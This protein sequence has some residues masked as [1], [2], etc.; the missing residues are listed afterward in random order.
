[1]TDETTDRD[2][3]GGPDSEARAS[4][5]AAGRRTSGRPEQGT[6]TSAREGEPGPSGPEGEENGAG[7][8]RRSGW[9]AGRSVWSETLSD[10][11]DVVGEVLESVRG[12]SAPGGRFPRY[13]LHRVE[14]EG[15]RILM[16]LPGVD[17]SDVEVRT[18]GDELSISGER[19]RPDLPEGAEAL[20]SERGFGRFRRSLRMPA[21][22]DRDAVSA[23][24]ED[25]VLEI[26]LPRE[27]RTRERT[28]E[29][30]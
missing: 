4:G 8:G 13:D 20:R 3:S 30:G 29:I 16:D 24:M 5:E 10:V 21:D 17:R 6:S 23:R 11:Q 14:G 19:R 15:Y 28:V 27:E 7:A 22:V 9:E 18:V 25:G 1:M 26:R 2:P 12:F